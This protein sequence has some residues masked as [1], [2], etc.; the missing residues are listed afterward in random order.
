[1]AEYTY[2]GY[3]VGS[4]DFAGSNVSLSSTYDQFGPDGRIIFNVVDDAG[5]NVR[6]GAGG[7]TDEGTVFDGDRYNNE[8]GDDRDQLGT[9]TDLA[10]AELFAE[11]NMYLEE[12][13]TLTPPTGPA[14]TLYLVEIDGTPVGYITSAPLIE[15]VTYSWTSDNVTP[16]NAPDSATPGDLVDVPCFGAGTLIRT[17]EGDQIIDTLKVGDLVT[18]ASGED[19][20]IRWIGQRTV[21]PPFAASQN[22][23]PVRIAKHALGD[24][25]PEHDLIV[26]PNHRMLVSSAASELLF[27]EPAVLVAAKFLVGLTGVE[28][29]TSVSS[30]S[31]F[32]ML[33]D[34]HEIVWSNGTKSESLYPG[35]MTLSGMARDVQDEIITIFPELQNDTIQTYGSIAAPV[36]KR[37]EAE[38]LSQYM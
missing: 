11:G 38:L 12:S 14:I 3:A 29:Q 19:Q 26:S 22:L 35:D 6:G 23:W 5:G 32:H 31:Y 36:L 20:A 17:P 8:G 21:L 2:V 24:G 37:Y 25:L 18:T 15:G 13:Y 16:T 4:I 34:K 28:K 27:G 33:F 30:I 1:M 10:G 9:V 7:R